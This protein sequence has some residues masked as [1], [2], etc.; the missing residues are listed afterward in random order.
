VS[1]KT[2]LMLIGLDSLSLS[3]LETWKGACPTVR[4]MMARCAV[5]CSA[6]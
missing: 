3:I 4:K 5:R 6:R 2:K 1:S